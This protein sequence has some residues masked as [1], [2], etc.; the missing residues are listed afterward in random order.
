VSHPTSAPSGQTLIQQRRGARTAAWLLPLAAL[1]GSTAAPATTYHNDLLFDAGTASVQQG[2]LESGPNRECHPVNGEVEDLGVPFVFRNHDPGMDHL[3]QAYEL[4]NNG[5]ERCVSVILKWQDQDCGD[6]EIN[7]GVALYLGDFD[8]SDPRVNLLSHSRERATDFFDL[9]KYPN[10]YRHSPGYY[11]VAG[12]DYKFEYMGAGATVPA[13]SKVTIV[14]N[15]RDQPG[16]TNTCPNKPGGDLILRSDELSDKPLELTVSDSSSYEYATDSVMTFYASLSQKL[17]EPVTIQWT[18]QAAGAG[19]GFATANADFTA[20]TD[21]ITF[22]PGETLKLIEVPILADDVE[23]PSEI[24]HLTLASVTHPALTI[25]DETATGTIFANDTPVVECSITSHAPDELPPGKVGVPYGPV[26]LVPDYHS[27]AGFVWDP[28]P[29]LPDGLTFDDEPSPSA[30]IEGTPTQSGIFE[31][32]LDL[33]CDG[34]ENDDGD[35]EAV[36]TLVIEPED[37][38]VLITLEDIAVV[39]GHVGFTDALPIIQLSAALPDDLL[40]EVITYDAEALVADDDYVPVPSGQLIQINAGETETPIPLQIVGDLTMELDEAFFVELRT[41]IEQ[42]VVASAIVT[43]IND[44][45][46]IVV[47]A[48]PSLDAVGLA[49][50]AAALLLAGGVVLRR[51]GT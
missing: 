32:F 11:R 37:P 33:H 47:P 45:G 40:L 10:D 39:E 14:L 50:L 23:E 51:S 44:D 41:P 15:S 25:V 22:Q 2:L 43:I 42:T 3:Y 48:V 12:F 5:P 16:S 17:V 8:P 9:S 7:I 35:Y 6:P 29:D 24:F 36:Y 13:F 31:I 18:S 21:T 49:F 1:V 30:T 19:A 20:M 28:F 38:P 4:Y 34:L 26:V 27:P 46:P